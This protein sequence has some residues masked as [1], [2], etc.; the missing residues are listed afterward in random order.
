MAEVVACDGR[1]YWRTLHFDW[2]ARGGAGH[3][4]R[5]VSRQFRLVCHTPPHRRSLL[6][7][8]KL[9]NLPTAA[10]RP[11]AA[12]ALKDY[13]LEKGSVLQL[14]E[15][16]LRGTTR[17]T[18]VGVCWNLWGPGSSDLGAREAGDRQVAAGLRQT[19]SGRRVGSIGIEEERVVPPK[20]GAGVVGVARAGW[21]AAEGRVP[22]AQ[23]RPGPLGTISKGPRLRDRDPGPASLG[24]L[25]HSRVPASSGDAPKSRGRAGRG[26]CDLRL[27][28]FCRPP[29][30]K[31]RRAEVA[32]C[33][34]RECSV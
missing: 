20:T 26:R 34:W 12:M 33:S 15:G 30:R 31:W 13:A 24:A 18:P 6:P 21:E 22:R 9:L 10:A 29:K 11:L 32:R 19:V 8:V 17:Q 14:W 7:G 23:K 2:P 5:D 16:I 4:G 25:G 28:V 1:E 27:A 3:V